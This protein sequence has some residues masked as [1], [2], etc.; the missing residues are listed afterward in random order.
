[1]RMDIIATAIENAIEKRCF[2]PALALSLVIPD[3]CAEY[4]YPE[5]YNKKAE[6]NG[7]K[8]H[9]A[10]YSKWYDENI[11]NYD[12]DPTTGIG[13]I[14]GKTCWKL[15]CEFL[16]SGSIDLDDFMS[17]DDKCI[18]FK[19]VSSEFSTD[20]KHFIG[21]CSGVSYSEDR[22]KMDIEIDVGNFCGKILAVFR[23]SY[24][25]DDNFI[26]TTENKALN[27]IEY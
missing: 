22:K 18:T 19:I 8:G 26:K 10:A 3:I 21:G 20:I 7:R 16:H 12:I 24:L 23:H 5:I 4:D 15:R 1:M 25:S 17:I 9:G 11:G 27:Y 2:L 14:D 13:L 6:Y